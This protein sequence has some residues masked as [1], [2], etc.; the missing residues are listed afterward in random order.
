MSVIVPVF[1][2]AEHIEQLHQEFSKLLPH[3]VQ[4]VFVDDCSSDGS[5]LLLR[6]ILDPEAGDVLITLPKNAGAGHCRNRG[7]EAAKGKYTMF[8]DVDDKPH[9]QAILSAIDKLE[10]N[11]NADVA[12]CAYTYE[13]D[14]PE[15]GSDMNKEDIRIFDRALGKQDHKAFPLEDNSATLM[16]TN[17]PWNKIIRT[18]TYRATGMKFGNTKV[19]NDI[20]GHW[21]M[22]LL[23][24]QIILTRDVVCS[25]IVR[26]NGGNITN[27]RNEKRLAV[28]AALNQV[29]DFLVAHPQMRRRYCHIYWE[30]AMRLLSWSK[31]RV[32]KAMHR[33]FD[34]LTTTL[35]TRIDLEDFVLI[36]SRRAPG[37]GNRIKDHFYRG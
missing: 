25:H 23:A 14:T 34:E 22:L 12:V 24:D 31:N 29:Y 21:M 2:G 3:G 1:N 30:F 15:L 36:Q 27:H 28:F 6:R 19:N 18:D 4:F 5:P 13:R 9:P 37:L 8:F 10:A 11:P 35:L 17:Y 16:I 32:D 7:W 26:S 20:L 33:R